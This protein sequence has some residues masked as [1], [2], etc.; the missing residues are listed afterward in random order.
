MLLELLLGSRVTLLSSALSLE[1]VCTAGASV[2]SVQHTTLVPSQL[3]RGKANCPTLQHCGLIPLK[4]N[5]C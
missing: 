4:L 5:V 2:C 3:C 1:V